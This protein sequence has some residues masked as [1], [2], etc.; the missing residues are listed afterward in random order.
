MNNGS[1]MDRPAKLEGEHKKYSLLIAN[2]VIEGMKIIARQNN[3]TA[4]TLFRKVVEDYVMNHEL[5]RDDSNG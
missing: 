5:F 2:G 1:Y 3:C 4:A